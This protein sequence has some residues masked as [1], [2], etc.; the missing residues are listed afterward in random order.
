MCSECFSWKRA[1][2]LGTKSYF[3][4]NILAAPI[5]LGLTAAAG[6]AR[7]PFTFSPIRFFVRKVPLD[8]D[9]DPFAF[10]GLKVFVPVFC[11]APTAAPTPL[12]SVPMV[13]CPTDPRGAARGRGPPRSGCCCHVSAPLPAFLPQR[14]HG[15]VLSAARLCA[16]PAHCSPRI[17][18]PRIAARPR[19]AQHGEEGRG[20]PPSVG[21][22]RG[23]RGVHGGGGEGSGGAGEAGE[24][25]AGPRE[26]GAG[27]GLYLESNFLPSLKVPL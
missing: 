11:R 6:A 23:G 26:A 4:S 22:V 17:G 27:R 15:H 3:S 1:A 7:A 13:R 24:N 20:A 18:S 9:R 5:A 25:P 14:T 8:R 21:A 12:T 10:Q 16:P 19:T 2:V